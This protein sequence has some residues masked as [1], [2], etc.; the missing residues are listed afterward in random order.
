M[1][2]G[3][4]NSKQKHSLGYLLKTL[5]SLFIR[6]FYLGLSLFYVRESIDS[7]IPHHINSSR[8]FSFVY[9]FSILS[10]RNREESPQQLR[11]EEVILKSVADWSRLRSVLSVRFAS[12]TRSVAN[13]GCRL[14][15]LKVGRPLSQSN[16][17]FSSGL[18]ESY[19]AL[20]NYTRM[21]QKQLGIYFFFF[22][23]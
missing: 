23:R 18:L 3:N 16:K 11:K 2:F 22:L 8:V 21:L 10:E 4:V 14:R 15:V 9:N 17:A 13:R 1:K 20:C 7:I 5:C 19:G 12:T 6:N